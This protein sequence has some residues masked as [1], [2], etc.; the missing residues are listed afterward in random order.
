MNL[1]DAL[2]KICT[3]ERWKR[4]INDRFFLRAVLSDLC[5]G[6]YTD[7]NSAQ[8]YS[9]V[10]KEVDLLGTV[11]KNGEGRAFNL[12]NGQFCGVSSITKEEYETCV[13]VTI[14]AVKKCRERIQ[15]EDC[16]KSAYCKQ[17]KKKRGHRKNKDFIIKNG[18]L[19]KYVGRH[20]KI[21]IPSSVKL[22]A[23]HAFGQEVLVREVTFH[24]K[25]KKI[26]AEAF[27]CC[28]NLVK[29]S[30]RDG[31]TEIEECAFA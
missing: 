29:I 9:K 30:L 8:I 6:C 14:S 13:N 27:Y 16:D 10:L 31:K 21:N 11:L 2:V 3:D 17:L 18:V 1:E 15:E 24:K 4:C 28:P 20:R 12:F 19:I 26:C 7:V 5:C 22:I 25:L 23:S